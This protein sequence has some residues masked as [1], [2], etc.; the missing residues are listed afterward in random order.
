MITSTYK[1]EPSYIAPLKNSADTLSMFKEKS[2]Y[3]LP[4]K[5]AVA[6]TIL[7]ASA[8]ASQIFNDDPRKIF[9][10]AYP[11]SPAPINSNVIATIEEPF[12]FENRDEVIKFIA[13]KADVLSL[14]KSLPVLIQ[15]VFGN[16]KVQLSIFKD[17]EENWSNLRVEIT[18][19]HEIDSLSA[20]EDQLF[21]L[22][23]KDKSF[24]AALDHVTISCG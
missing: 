4:S 17:Y 6:T 20:L 16:A 13:G 2:G 12:S 19:G 11:L 23:E 10:T 9:P 5:V 3:Y 1:T 15:S 7:L 21:K 24:I 18:S 14:Y 8:L 22:L